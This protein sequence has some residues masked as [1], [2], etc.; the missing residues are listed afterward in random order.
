MNYA[1]TLLI[2]YVSYIYSKIPSSFAIL[3][4]ASTSSTG[5]AVLIAGQPG[6]G[7]TA[8]A[9]ALAQSLGS[10]TPFTVLSA[11]EIF[12]Y[13]VVGIQVLGQRIWAP[14]GLYY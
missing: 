11:S 6:S 5:Q 1:V 9:M 4:I 14:V 12:R 7:K 3:Y 13:L 10:D 2:S 8:L